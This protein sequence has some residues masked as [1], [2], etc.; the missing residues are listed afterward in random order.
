MWQGQTDA[1]DPMQTALVFELSIDQ[2]MDMQQS[3]TVGLHGS[4][5]SLAFEHIEFVRLRSRQTN[6]R[7]RK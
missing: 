2:G 3:G 7:K 1:N 5:R 6:K 4:V